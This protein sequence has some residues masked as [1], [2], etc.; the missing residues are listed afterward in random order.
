MPHPIVGVL[1]G[2]AGLAV[3]PGVRQPRSLLRRS[4]LRSCRFFITAPD[5]YQP[6]RLFR[7]QD[8][9]LGGAHRP[10]TKA[11]AHATA[12]QKAVQNR[13]NFPLVADL[14]NSH[15]RLE[16]QRSVAQMGAA[17]L[18]HESLPSQSKAP[19]CRPLTRADSH[20]IPGTW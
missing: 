2:A 5:R 13:T 20:L 4:L 10:N 17:I 16:T 9:S 7:I 6:L 3:F 11:V 14:G 18:R 15:S 1:S 12:L 19:R 8:R